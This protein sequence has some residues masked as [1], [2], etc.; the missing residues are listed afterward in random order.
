MDLQH[1]ERSEGG[2]V[3]NERICSF[4]YK[5]LDDSCPCRRIVCR[6]HLSVFQGS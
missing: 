2:F 5:F 1:L 4:M 6:V 3:F